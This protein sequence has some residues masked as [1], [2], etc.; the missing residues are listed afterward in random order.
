[1][2]C[3]PMVGVPVNQAIT[4]FCPGAMSVSKRITIL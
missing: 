1:M 3:V 4:S 2:Q